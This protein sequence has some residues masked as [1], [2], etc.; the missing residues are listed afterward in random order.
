MSLKLRHGALKCQ[1]SGGQGCTLHNANKFSFL[2]F[3][4]NK[5]IHKAIKKADSWGANVAKSKIKSE[6]KNYQL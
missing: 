3:F 6:K 1:R 4:L 2:S 5:A